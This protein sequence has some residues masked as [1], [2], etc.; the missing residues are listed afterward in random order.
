V[1]VFVDDTKYSAA[2]L[3]VSNSK[4]TAIWVDLQHLGSWQL[5]LKVNLSITQAFYFIIHYLSISQLR[6]TPYGEMA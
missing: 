6:T 1:P 4:V 3:S 2:A 5:K